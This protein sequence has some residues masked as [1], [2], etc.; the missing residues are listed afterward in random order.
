MLMASLARRLAD[1]NLATRQFHRCRRSLR[2]QI[3]RELRARRKQPPKPPPNPQTESNVSAYW[4]FQ[5]FRLHFAGGFF[6]IGDQMRRRRTFSKK[7]E[8]S[9]AKNLHPHKGG[10]KAFT[11]AVQNRCAAWPHPSLCRRSGR[12]GANPQRQTSATRPVS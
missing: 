12:P 5:F 1:R 9:K 11:T 4:S 10:I 2:S 7:R 6:L 3:A 8:G